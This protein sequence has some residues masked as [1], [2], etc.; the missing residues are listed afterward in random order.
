MSTI[1][2]IKG[3]TLDLDI[4]YSKKRVRFDWSDWLAEVDPDT[5]QSAVINNSSDVTIS[6]KTETTTT[7]T[8][9]VGASGS[10]VV[11]NKASVTCV[12]TTVAGQSEARTIHFNI[13]DRL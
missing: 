4:T 11:G 7:V 13:V 5:I 10:A 8:C 2:W 1:T 12:I 9:V 6:G 3:L